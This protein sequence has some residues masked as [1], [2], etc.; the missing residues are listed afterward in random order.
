MLL[1]DCFVNETNCQCNYVK[2]IYLL[3]MVSIEMNSPP[4]CCQRIFNECCKC[5]IEHTSQHHEIKFPFYF[6]SS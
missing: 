2:F 4:S 1:V 5:V 3:L 6:S